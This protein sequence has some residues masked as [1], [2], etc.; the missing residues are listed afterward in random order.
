[1]KAVGLEKKRKQS[2]QKLRSA[3]SMHEKHEPVG[4]RLFV[5]IP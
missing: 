4:L 5:V 1:M 2:K 3:H